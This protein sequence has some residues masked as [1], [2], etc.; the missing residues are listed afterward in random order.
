MLAKLVPSKPSLAL[1][2]RKAS[3]AEF[4]GC[5]QV[6]E[7]SLPPNPR[8]GR[9]HTLDVVGDAH[10]QGPAQQRFQDLLCTLP[11][12]LSASPSG[13]DLQTP[14]SRGSTEEG[15]E[16]GI[17]PERWHHSGVRAPKIK[18]REDSRPA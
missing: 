11:T 6:S 12:P 8:R 15:G 13:L 7:P 10:G 14:E 3:Q 5:W 18:R 2:E 17:H 16:G 4:G 9:G 1:K